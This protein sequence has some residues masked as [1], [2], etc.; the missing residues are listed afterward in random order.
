MDSNEIKIEKITSKINIH[1][2]RVWEHK[3]EKRIRETKGG[4]DVGR[5]E[6]KEKKKK[7]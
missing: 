6:D 5:G 1:K 4:C 3:T 2:E 7:R